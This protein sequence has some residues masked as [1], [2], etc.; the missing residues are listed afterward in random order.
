MV[1]EALKTLVNIEAHLLPGPELDRLHDG[2][3]RKVEGQVLVVAGDDLRHDL[4]NLAAVEERVLLGQE[5]SAGQE[6]LGGR[7]QELAVPRGHQVRLVAH[8]D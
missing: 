5:I 3:R 8:Q 7:D 4:A 1:A 6:V 2:R